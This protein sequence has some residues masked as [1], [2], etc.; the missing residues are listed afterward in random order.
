ML[1][2][3]ASLCFVLLI[4][5]ALTA[6][7]G[8][9]NGTGSGEGENK[10]SETS[11]RK[12]T[13]TTE[14]EP[15]PVEDEPE[16]IDMSGKPI[17]VVSWG[18]AGG[19]E[20]TDQGEKKI[21]MEKEMAEKHNTK[22]QFDIIPWDGIQDKVTASIIAG[23]P[24]A[25][26]FMLDRYRAF[27]AMVEND[28]LMPLSDIVDLTDP[29]WH[30][31]LKE[32]GGYNDTVYGFATDFGGGGG[33]YYNRAILAKEGLTDPQELHEQG[34][35]NWD[36]F[37]DI[38]KK[39]TK[40]T[41]GDGQ[42]DQYGVSINSVN[43]VRA[44]ISSNDTDLTKMDNGKMVYDGDN[45]NAMEALHFFNDLYHV[46]KVV[47]PNQSG[48]WD[49]YITSFNEGNIAMRYGE[50]W[51]GGGIQEALGKDYGFVYIPKGPKANEYS[52]SLTNVSLW[53]VP[54]GA[55][56]DAVRLYIDYM[57]ANKA[58]EGE[59]DAWTESLFA[60]QKSL[61]IYLEMGQYM[62]SPDWAGIP[63]FEAK[64]REVWDNIAAGKE[65][66][67]TGM[68]KVRPVMEGLMNASE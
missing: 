29:K 56:P 52:N 13:A 11:D 6:C 8:N 2:K 14:P 67:E 50:G 57:F 16:V 45:P 5:A 65:T 28:M 25:D 40:D 51:E 26:V 39:T 64:M 62:T 21:A 31:R 60:D 37:L 55:N 19:E 32:I 1:K 35:W 63:D 18:Y 24:I 15:N 9:N 47:K 36:A 41:N 27:P 54:K 33:I 30:G 61:D 23:E 12:E 43:F 68:A 53:F 58:P 22:F 59:I 17:R 7:S 44:F 20:G 46:H 42:L 34:M 66:P 49:D 38:A 3:Y 4:V 48:S 10:G